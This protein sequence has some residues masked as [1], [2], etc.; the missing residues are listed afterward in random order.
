V[1]STLR[2]VESLIVWERH[3]A[4]VADAVIEAILSMQIF[5]HLLILYNLY[6]FSG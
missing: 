3:R 6:C 2:G 1:I 5:Y 4:Q